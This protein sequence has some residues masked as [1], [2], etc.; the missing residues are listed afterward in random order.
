MAN[1]T[2]IFL[3]TYTDTEGAETERLI[4]AASAH[5]A[6]KALHVCKAS[7]SDVA[8]VLGAGGTV[9]KAAA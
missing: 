1:E 2:A 4:E 8:R 6:R 5:E 9:E 7:A 3:L